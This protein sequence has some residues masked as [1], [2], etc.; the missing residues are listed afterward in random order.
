MADV[1]QEVESSPISQEETTQVEAPQEAQPAESASADDGVDAKASLLSVVQDA[2]QPKDDAEATA[3]QADEESTDTD[4]SQDEAGQKDAQGQDE[5]DEFADVG[6]RK[7]PRFQQLIRERNAYKGDAQEYRKIQTFLSENG[8]SAE[9]AGEMLQIG[10]LMERNPAQALEQLR[11]HL[12]K[13]VQE[14]GAVLPNDLQDRVRKGELTKDA[15]AEISRLRAQQAGT[16]REQQFQQEQAERQR[17][18]QAA[19]GMRNAAASW[20]RTVRQRDPDFDALME[21]V[22]REIVYRHSKGERPSDPDGV[23]KQLD[24]AYAAV[25]KRTRPAAPPKRPVQPVTGGRAAASQAQEPTSILDIVK[26]Y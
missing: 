18:Q 7:H 6:F 23:K 17:Q 5:G 4:T 15:A 14:A 1:E 25:K 26:S 10:A 20:E 9:R 2:V 16:Q 22:E 21:D 13:L 11:P 8:L 19:E 12:Q 24:E 3:S